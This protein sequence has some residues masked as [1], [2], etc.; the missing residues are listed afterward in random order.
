MIDAV[1]AA[2]HVLPLF[3]RTITVDVLFTGIGV[4]EDSM[5]D[6]SKLKLKSLS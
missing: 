1:D 4:P 3:A 2:L 6:A 5:M